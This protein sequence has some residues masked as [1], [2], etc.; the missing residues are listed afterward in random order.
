MI[1]EEPALP[2]TGGG[3]RPEHTMRAR[4]MTLI[5]IG[6]ALAIAAGLLAMAIPAISNV[7][8]VQLRQK[9]GQLASGV[10][11]LYGAAA[12]AGHSCRLVLDIDNEVYWSEC[13]EGAVRLDRAGEQSAGGARSVTREEEQLANIRPDSANEEDQVKLALAQKSAFKPSGDI[14]R[15]QLGGSV[16]FLDVWVQHQTERYTSGKAFLYFWPSGLTEVAAIHLGQ[17]DDV[18]T[19]LVSPL[20]GRVKIV[21]GRVDAEGQK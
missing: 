2:A 10:R 11:S 12:L 14:P 18:Y 3:R 17:G 9:T 4:G 16:R 13:A 21:S 8:R 20:S 7:T 6:I 1:Q 15:T 19:L 5:E